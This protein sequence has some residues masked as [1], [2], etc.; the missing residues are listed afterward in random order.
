MVIT[1][2]M[3]VIK[4]SD[5]YVWSSNFLKKNSSNNALLVKCLIYFF[6]SFS[7]V[8]IQTR[9]KCWQLI[10]TKFKSVHSVRQLVF[11][12]FSSQ[13]TKKRPD[14]S[15]PSNSPLLVLFIPTKMRHI[16]S[17][18][19]YILFIFKKKKKQ[20]KHW[21]EANLGCHWKCESFQDILRKKEAWCNFFQLDV[22]RHCH[23]KSYSKTKNNVYNKHQKFM[24][25][26]N[27]IVWVFGL[28]S[29]ATQKLYLLRMNC[30][31]T[32]LPPPPPPL[33]ITTLTKRAQKS[34]GIYV[35]TPR[36]V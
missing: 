16:E 6:A 7:C 30:E 20:K 24:S 26:L 13:F 32:L 3:I 4:K 11:C 15:P 27:D 25:C 9:M 2:Y 18:F 14:I 31:W 23:E 10:R 29:R 21:L 33:T 28:K 36:N 35:K 17:L 34:F 1:L 8:L 5:I 22:K 12:R 19:F